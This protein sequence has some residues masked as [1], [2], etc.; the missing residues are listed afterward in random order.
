MLVGCI[1]QLL[2]LMKI[3]PDNKP[4]DFLSRFWFDQSDQ[5]SHQHSL[6]KFRHIELDG[7]GRNF[8]L[9]LNKNKSYASEAF[10]DTY[11]NLS[12]AVKN[13]TLFITSLNKRGNYITLDIGHQLSH[14]TVKHADVNV[15]IAQELVDNMHL[16]VLG[17]SEFVFNH[18]TRE[19]ADTL[20]KVIPKLTVVVSE[21]SKAYLLDSYIGQLDVDLQE[22]LLRYSPKLKVDTMNVKLAGK[23]AVSSTQFDDNNQ[24]HVLNVS[25]DK[26]Y[27]RKELIGQNVQLN[28]I[29]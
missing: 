11:K 2:G 23:S 20:Q 14:L 18:F 22:G 24:V 8:S 27:F 5:P 13:D 15:I 10:S 7:G 4:V 25:G 19:E 28:L 9:T 1:P 3:G 26:D 21:Q 16:N 6:P 17:Q 29:K 12:V